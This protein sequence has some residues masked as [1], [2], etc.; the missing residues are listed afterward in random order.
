MNVEQSYPIEAAAPA[1]R[2]GLSSWIKK[3]RWFVAFVVL[4]TIL[5]AIYYGFIAADVYISEA[6]FVI[7]SPDQKRPQLSSLANLI[8]TTGLSSGQEQANEVLE[9]VRSRDALKALAKDTNIAQRFGSSEADRFSRFPLPL[10]DG[11]FEDLYK[12]YS[13]MVSASLDNESSTAILTVKAFTPE[14][15]YR[16]NLRLLNLSEQMVN[17]LNA[18]AQNRGIAEA[19]KQVQEASERVR[20]VRAALTGYRNSAELID[21]AKQAV[22]V[23]EI[24]NGLI[25]Q[26]SL[27]EAQLETMQRLTPDNPSIPALRR[28]ISAISSQISS[29]NSRV[30]GTGDGIASKLGGYE[31]LISEQEFATESL[32]AANAGLVQARMDAQRQQF[33]L[34]RIVDPNKPDMPLL[35]RR[36]LSIITVA[37]AAT[38]LYFIGWMLI[39]GILEHAPED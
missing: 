30:T 33:Y 24:S 19:E 37:A 22:G 9:F 3:R 34:E 10:S 17:R 2:S 20:R 1:H 31:N 16:I 11:S 36:L 38:C 7:K 23:I 15:A 29:Q 13:K 39:V 8:Q 6:R 25:A 26:R 32:T 5:A 12:F 14:D 27:L 21:P 4:P 18:R 35:P 28:Q